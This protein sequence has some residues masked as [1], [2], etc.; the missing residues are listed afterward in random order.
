MKDLKPLLK[1]LS[2]VSGIPG[3]LSNF[4]MDEMEVLAELKEKDYVFFD[5]KRTVW[6]TMEGL[7]STDSPP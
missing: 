5:N 1:K 7:L 4:S 2:S 6:L 3:N